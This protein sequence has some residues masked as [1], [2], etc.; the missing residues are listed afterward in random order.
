MHRIPNRKPRRIL[1]A[2][3][4]TASAVAPL[5]AIAQTKF[6]EPTKDE[7]AMTAQPG[8]PGVAAVVL[9]REQ[10]YYDD[11][12]MS[13]TYER[14]KILTEDGKKYANVELPY[15]VTSGDVSNDTIG[16]EKSLDN[17]QGRT[18]HAD[19]TIVP[20]T[21]KP[22]LKVMEKGK[23]FKYQAKVFTLPDVTVGS[24]IEYRYNTSINDRGYEPPTW[25]VQGALYVK[26]A[27]YVWY[28][29]S[30][31]LADEHGS[32]INTITWFPILP[33]NAELTHHDLP[34]TGG[35]NGMPSRSYELTVNDVPPVVEEEFMPPL[36]NYSFRVYFSYI[37]AHTGRRVLEGRRKVLVQEGQLLLQS[38][39]GAERRHPED[40]R[41]RHYAGPETPRHL[42]RRSDV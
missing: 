39:L 6:K 29:S 2:L 20:F 14:I 16:N 1:T 18:I 23:G 19:G 40:H 41:G 38:Q 31:D 4:L 7:L 13:S 42:C 15:V 21:G 10:I 11:K 35:R 30:E 5:A 26:A 32:L 25:I 24:I 12:H 22:Y 27:H 37:A 34:G 17:I 33:K 8:F 9:D 28:P 36:A 3:L